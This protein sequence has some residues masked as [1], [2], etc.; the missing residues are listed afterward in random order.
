MSKPPYTMT[1]EQHRE[2]QTRSYRVPPV[3]DETNGDGLIWPGN[4]AQIRYSHGELIAGELVYVESFTNA[5]FRGIEASVRRPDG[6]R[7]CTSAGN[8]DQVREN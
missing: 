3:T 8:L 4:L 2:C 6:K 1:S 5:G 7:H